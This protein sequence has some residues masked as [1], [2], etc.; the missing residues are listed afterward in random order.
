M[1]H[2]TRLRRFVAWYL[3]YI[4]IVVGVL[5]GLWVQEENRDRAIRD[6]QEARYAICVST[7]DLHDT[8]HDL[9]VTAGVPLQPPPGSDPTLVEA[10]NKS[11]ALAAMY[12][13]EQLDRLGPPIVC[14]RP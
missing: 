12:R 9:I 2:S 6:A 3:P 5:I 4:F 10:I 7:R 8:L 13:A 11:N 14:H 1:T